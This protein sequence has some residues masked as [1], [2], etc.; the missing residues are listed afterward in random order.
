LDRIPLIGQGQNV[1]NKFNID[2]YFEQFLTKNYNKLETSQL[3][4]KPTKKR[5][6]KSCG[7]KFKKRVFNRKAIKCKWC[8]HSDNFNSC[9][10]YML[11]DTIKY[12]RKYSRWIK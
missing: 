7:K 12:Y 10:I 3:F 6:C 9:S 11:S 2:K 4:I 5:I 8:Y 1:M